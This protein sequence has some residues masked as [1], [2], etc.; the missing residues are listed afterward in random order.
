MVQKFTYVDE[1]FPYLA[2]NFKDQT[3][4]H[5]TKSCKDYV[6]LICPCCGGEY[7]SRVVD[8]IRSGH[9]PC[10]LCNDGYP[11]PEKLMGNILLQLNINYEYQFSPKWVK[12]Y[13]YDFM[14][15]YNNVSYIVEMDGGLGH[16][17][18]DSYNKTAEECLEIDKI[19]D[20]LANK[21]GFNV[22]RIDCNYNNYNRFN[23]IKE[24]IVK[25]LENILP[26][27]NVDWE[28]CNEKSLISK[29][30]EVLDI[31]KTQTKCLEEISELSHI[32]TR[33]VI[34]YITE[35][36]D[37][38]L[39]PKSKLD[40]KKVKRKNRVPISEPRIIS[41]SEANAR[42]IYCYEDVLLFKTLTDVALYYGFNRGS[43]SI[44]MNK[45]GG[46]YKGRH[47][48]KYCDLPKDFDFHRIIFS[49]NDYCN[50][51]SKKIICQYTL[52]DKLKHIYIRKEEL[53]KDM[54]LSNIWRSCVGQR[55]SAYGYKWEILDKQNEFEIFEMIRAN[56]IAR[57]YFAN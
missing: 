13:R 10:L 14:F 4:T 18:N 25:R 37:V 30:K 40:I 56:E 54:Y 43:F 11:Y 27:N 2:K 20:D 21:H 31:Y 47:F 41:S 57:F 7:T 36:M 33:T 49:E 8:Y 29:F 12:P 39:I 6:K 46:Y 51:S 28:L 9:V 16:G 32:K 53:P 35:A 26:L 23:Y 42:S 44:A 22:I 34:K 3:K 52:D 55:D 5:V 50:S 19:K 24:N 38:G 15:I 1:S 17:Y 48:V 45:N